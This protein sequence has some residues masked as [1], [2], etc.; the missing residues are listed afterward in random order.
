MCLSERSINIE[1][2]LSNTPLFHGLESK[3]VARVARGTHAI[4]APGGQVVF[5]EEERPAGFHLIVYGQVKLVCGSPQGTEKVVDILDQGQTFGEAAMFLD[6]KHLVTA[7]T[8][9][10]SLLLH[11][12]KGA[13]LNELDK[14]PQFAL[15]MIAG[16]SLQL[17]QLLGDVELYSL[18][19]GC[20]RI[21]AYLLRGQPADRDESLTVTL[22]VNKGVLASRLN[23]AP[24]TFSRILCELSAKGLLL[25]EGRRIHIPDVS[26]LRAYDSDSRSVT[27][28]V[29]GLHQQ[30]YRRRTASFRCEAEMT[31]L[32]D[33]TDAE[34]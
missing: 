6:S 8:L 30:A 11:I 23:M 4:A 2:F 17:N 3:A 18:Y 13:M 29:P 12:S 34:N 33:C 15:K 31:S 7:Q 25:V 16:L 22:T 21:V 1:A 24:E 28:R 26:K 27:F 10:N 32:K 20:D 19:S 9:T 14:A 5:R